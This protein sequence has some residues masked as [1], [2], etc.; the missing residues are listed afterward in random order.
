RPVDLLLGV[1]GRE[2]EDA[3]RRIE[4]P[5]SRD[6]LDAGHSR[7]P[8]IDQRDVRPVDV[9]ELHRLRTVGGFRDHLQIRLGAEGTRQAHADEEVIVHDEHGDA[10]LSLHARSYEASGTSAATSVPAPG[11]LAT[12]SVPPSLLARSRIPSRPNDPPVV[13]PSGGTKPHPSSATRSRTALVS[14]ASSTSSR[15]ARA[16]L[17]AFVIASCPIRSRLVSVIAGS[18][19]GSPMMRTSVRS[20]PSAVRSRAAFASADARFPCSSAYARSSQTDRRTSAMQCITISRAS[21]R[22]RSA[23]AGALRTL[24]AA[25]SSWSVTPPNPASPGS[26]TP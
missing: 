4:R 3:G 26:T 10:F 5:D 17:T 13:P 15:E 8:Q 6:G 24:A 14:N 1:I 23:C 16:C 12:V 19:L 21:A 25:T 11:R 18:G 7:K 20:A 2:R 22:W 9:E